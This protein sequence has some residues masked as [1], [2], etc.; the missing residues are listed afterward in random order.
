[1]ALLNKANILGAG[2]LAH[3]DVDVPEWGGSVRIRVMTGAER[4]QFEAMNVKRTASGGA[5]FDGTNYLAKLIA[6]CAVDADGNKLF[7]VDDI[8]ALGSKNGS[9]LTRVFRV[10][11]E[12]N[13]LGVEAREA[14]RKP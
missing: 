10:A 1:M 8:E 4:A 7:T 2:D 11:Q 5:E 3:Q 6:M 12:L 13:G 14:A 9:V